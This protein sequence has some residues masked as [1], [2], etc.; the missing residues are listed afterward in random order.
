M[1]AFSGLGYYLYNTEWVSSSPRKQG[2]ERQWELTRVGCSIRQRAILA[3]KK[4]QLLRMRERE[5]AL[6]SAGGDHEEHH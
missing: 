5:A 3:E 4:D 2:H 6:V 1:G